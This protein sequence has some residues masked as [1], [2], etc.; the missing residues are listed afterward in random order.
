VVNVVA[1][2]GLTGA[3]LVKHP[4]VSRIGFV[5]SVETGRLVARAP[6]TFSSA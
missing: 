5:G 1:G 4:M 2:D 3:E 6:P